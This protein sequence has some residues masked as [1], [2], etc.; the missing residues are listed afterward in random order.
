MISLSEVFDKDGLAEFKARHVGLQ[1]KIDDILRAEIHRIEIPDNP[2]TAYKKAVT[3]AM[4]DIERA[5]SQMGDVLG[6]LCGGLVFLQLLD[7]E[8]AE[9]LSSVVDRLEAENE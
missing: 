5:F 8:T 2:S 1:K 9:R 4:T 6:A 3:M 7:D